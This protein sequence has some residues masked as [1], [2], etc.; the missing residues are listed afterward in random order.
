[1]GLAL[2]MRVDLRGRLGAHGGVNEF[3]F[4]AVLLAGGQSSRM[5]RDKATLRW[6]GR[7]LWEH[8]LATLGGLQP[9]ELFVSGPPGTFQGVTVVPDEQPRLGPLG[10]LVASLRHA[11][12]P[13][14]LVLAVDLPLISGELLQGL[15][16]CAQECEA[17]VIPKTARGFE[18]LAAVYPKNALADAEAALIG[19]RRSLQPFVEGLIA[20]GSAVPFPV[21]KGDEWQFTNP[22]TPAEWKALTDEQRVSRSAR[23]PSSGQ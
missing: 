23:P 22:N 18:P 20:S 2:K 1:M 7:L 12:S 17:G 15:L 4:S 6:E 9:A 21:A 13:W 19:S 10:G 8:Q 3:A 11:H 16:R 14:L 5:G